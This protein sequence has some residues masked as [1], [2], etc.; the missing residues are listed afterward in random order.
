MS[1]GSPI[2]AIAGL[3]PSL[4]SIEISRQTLIQP[5]SLVGLLERLEKRGYVARVRSVEDRRIVFAT[6]TPTGRALGTAIAPALREIHDM[7]DARLSPDEW[8]QLLRL[9]GKV[10]QPG[11]TKEKDHG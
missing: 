5:N 3:T 11:I 8:D 4:S 9:L 7:I 10:A 2:T 6:L 1:V